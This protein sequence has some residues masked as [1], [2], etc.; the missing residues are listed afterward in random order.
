MALTQVN[1]LGGMV[2]TA[3]EPVKVLLKTASV[4]WMKRSGIRDDRSPETPLHDYSLGREAFN[5]T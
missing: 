1:A 2:R 5:I 3:C 4:A